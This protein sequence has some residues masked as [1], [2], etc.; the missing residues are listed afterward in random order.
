MSLRCDT[1]REGR[2]GKSEFDLV[3]VILPLLRPEPRANLAHQHPP[4]SSLVYGVQKLALKCVSLTL[5]AARADA[6]ESQR[7]QRE[8]AVKLLDTLNGALSAMAV[9]TGTAAHDLLAY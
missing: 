1:R 7:L 8:A 2:L 6:L 9:G 3:D 4:P 5:G